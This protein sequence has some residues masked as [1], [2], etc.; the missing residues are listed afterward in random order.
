MKNNT[1]NLPP[2][3]YFFEMCLQKVYR[4]FVIISWFGDICNLSIM[5]VFDVPSTSRIAY[6]TMTI[7]KEKIPPILACFKISPVT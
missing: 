6:V 5:M 1:I 4:Y 7:I 3:L 2:G